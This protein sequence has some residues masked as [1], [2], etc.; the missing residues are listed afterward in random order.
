MYVRT[1]ILHYVDA[2][3]EI[4]G[5]LTASATGIPGNNLENIHKAIEVISS[6]FFGKVLYGLADGSYEAKY[7]PSPANCATSYFFELRLDDGLVIV[8]DLRGISKA[9]A[10]N[11]DEYGE[12]L[13]E[14]MG[15]AFTAVRWGYPLARN[16]SEC[17]D[18]AAEVIAE[19][20]ARGGSEPAAH[21]DL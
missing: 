4:G 17:Q 14:R 15:A 10:L 2:S 12:Y 3:E 9:F 7:Q 16:W 13:C 6:E 20:Q 8:L 5:V 19:A 18:W 1:R 21:Q 11:R